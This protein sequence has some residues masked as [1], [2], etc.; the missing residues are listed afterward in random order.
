M[1]PD[2]DLSLVGYDNVSLS[3]SRRFQSTWCLHL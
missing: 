1:M 2:K 3:G